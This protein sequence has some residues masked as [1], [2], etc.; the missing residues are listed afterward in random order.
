MGYGSSSHQQDDQGTASAFK[1]PDLGDVFQ[2]PAAKV[3]CTALYIDEVNSTETKTK[4][5][6][7]QCVNTAAAYPGEPIQPVALPAPPE[8][9]SP[10]RVRCAQWPTRSE[11][12]T[13]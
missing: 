12:G 1:I 2:T 10:S 6:E 3:Q 11:G 4:V 7:A 8:L 9:S 13:A 5:P